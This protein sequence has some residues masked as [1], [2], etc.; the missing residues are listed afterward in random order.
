MNPQLKNPKFYTMILT[1]GFVF[2]VALFLSYLIRFEFSFANIN[3]E[4]ISVLLLWIVP[5]KFIIFLSFGLY[6]GMW[7]YTSVRDFWL[8]IR[9][10][11]ALRA[12]AGATTTVV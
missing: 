12:E 3:I 8:L 7:R 6:S 11:R 2:I 9:A 5:L 1:D 10:W 4:Q